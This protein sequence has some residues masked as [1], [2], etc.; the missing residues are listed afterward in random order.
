MGCSKPK[1]TSAYSLFHFAWLKQCAVITEYIAGI[2]ELNFVKEECNNRLT[3]M[4]S[5][6]LVDEQVDG[7]FTKN[8]EYGFVRSI[9]SM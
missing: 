6:I 8:P 7:C 1:G 5:I 3:A 9:Y 2:P 4:I